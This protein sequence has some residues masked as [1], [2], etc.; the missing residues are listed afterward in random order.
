MF[1]SLQPEAENMSF[2]RAVLTLYKLAKIQIQR[3][4]TSSRFAQLHP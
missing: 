4:S 3:L 2:Y 1:A